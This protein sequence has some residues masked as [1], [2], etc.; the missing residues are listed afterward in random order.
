M[1]TRCASVDLA[2][3][4]IRVNSVNP[5][6]VMTNLQKTGGMSDEAYKGFIQRSIEVT[7]PLASALGRCAQPEEV[8]EAIVFLASPQASFVE[9]VYKLT[10][11]EGIWE[12]ARAR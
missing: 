12:H 4:G 9:L 1:L 2:P 7:H 11:V 5:G 8:A 10:E 3:F 6:V